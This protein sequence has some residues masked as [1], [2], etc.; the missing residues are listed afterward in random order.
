MLV[1]KGNYNLLGLKLNNNQND[2]PTIQ[3]FTNSLSKIVEKDNSIE[4]KIKKSA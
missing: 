2:I 4:D 1:V 3:D